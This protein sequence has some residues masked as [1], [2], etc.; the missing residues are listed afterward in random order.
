MHIQRQ[1]HQPHYLALKF[2]QVDTQRLVTLQPVIFRTVVTMSPTLRSGWG[3]QIQSTIIKDREG[4]RVCFELGGAEKGHHQLIDSLS[5]CVCAN[6]GCVLTNQ[7]SSFSSMIRHHGQ[8]ALFTTSEHVNL[9]RKRNGGMK[10][11]RIQERRWTRQ[12]GSSIRITSP[13]RRGKTK[14]D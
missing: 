10:S 5:V 6:I 8:T 2:H 3:P 9:T 4:S 13:N 12:N 14:R 7:S 11:S 1:L